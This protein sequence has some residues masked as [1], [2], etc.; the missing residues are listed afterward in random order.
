MEI[1]SSGAKSDCRSTSALN[2]DHLK[3]SWTDHAQLK[4]FAIGIIV[5]NYAGS[6]RVINPHQNSDREPGIQFSSVSD[7]YV[8]T[9]AAE[10]L[11]GPTFSTIGALTKFG[12]Y[13]SCI[14]V[15]CSADIGPTASSV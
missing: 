12:S 10:K 3:D 2:D 6:S 4:L 1:D 5:Q 7:L 9:A 11:S 8:A 13:K 15:F 14:W